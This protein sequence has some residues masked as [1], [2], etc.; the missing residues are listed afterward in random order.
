MRST[1]EQKIKVNRQTDKPN[2]NMT[3]HK[4]IRWVEPNKWY[5]FE[6]E[7]PFFV[8]SND[9]NIQMNQD[10]I[11]ET[12]PKHIKVIP[13]SQ[14]EPILYDTTDNNIF[15]KNGSMC[16][17]EFTIPTAD[18]TAGNLKFYNCFLIKCNQCIQFNQEM[19]I[20]IM[21]IGE[22]Y[23]KDYL[24]NHGGFFI[25]WHNTP[26]FHAPL[27]TSSGGYL[28]LGKKQDQGFILSRFKIP[29]GYGIFTSP[30]VIHC[31]S[32]LIGDYLVSYTIAKEWKTYSILNEDNQSFNP[33][34]SWA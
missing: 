9:E 11:K 12:I 33:F 14:K 1:I 28:I 5:K 21:K 19:P 25:E 10:I 29:Y 20:T 24:L 27:T 8:L 13:K 22:N 16:F 32:G 34:V 26:H 18:T 3:T 4:I 6:I 30:N 15:G 2:S 7:R 31:D 23:V 17:K